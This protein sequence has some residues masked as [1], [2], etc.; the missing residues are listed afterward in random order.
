MRLGFNQ[1][2]RERERER[3]IFLGI[4]T[5]MKVGTQGLLSGRVKRVEEAVF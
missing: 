4:R 2:Q 3:E 5:G 1:G